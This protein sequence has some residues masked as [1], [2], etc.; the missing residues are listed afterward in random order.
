[1]IGEL[2]AIA[3]VL[4]LPAAIFLGMLAAVGLAV[5]GV[6]IGGERG[7]SSVADAGQPRTTGPA[8]RIS[9]DAPSA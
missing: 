7:A 3:I 4:V 6:A 5:A 8:A 1:M 9:S 2:V